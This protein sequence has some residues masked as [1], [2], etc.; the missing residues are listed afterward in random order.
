[1]LRIGDL[2]HRVTPIFDL[3]HR[4]TLERACEFVCGHLILLASKKLPS[5]ASTNLSAISTHGTV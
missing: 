5:K 2:V 3:G 1:M 4:I